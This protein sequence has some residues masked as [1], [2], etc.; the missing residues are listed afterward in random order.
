MQNV[1]Y[2]I[3]VKNKDPHMNDKHG[4]F[5][6][7]DVSRK[8]WEWWCQKNNV[9]FVPYELSDYNPEKPGT[10][11]TWQRWF[12]MKR[13]ISD[14]GITPNWIWAVDVDVLRRQTRGRYL[15]LSQDIS[16]AMYYEH[17]VRC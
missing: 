13:V 1:V 3:G 2:W 15:V 14:K 5:S 8:T 4:G 6:Y 10:K 17:V 11:V 9:V 16:H 7:L 12:D